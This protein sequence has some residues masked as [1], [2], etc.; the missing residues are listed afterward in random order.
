MMALEFALSYGD[1][2]CQV[3][4][5]LPAQAVCRILSVRITD[6]FGDVATAQPPPGRWNLFRH[7]D[8]AA[9]SGLGDVF[10]NAVP[11]VVADGEPIEEVHFLRDEQANLAWAVE[12]VVPHPLGGGVPAPPPPPAVPPPAG[13]AGPRWTLSPA[14]LPREWFP[15]L[16]VDDPPGRLVVGGLWT[17]RDVR[18]AGRV[19]GELL[20]DGRLQDREVP[21]KGVQVTRCWQAARGPDGSLHLWVGRAKTPRR[22]ELAPAVRFDLVDG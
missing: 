17:A 20:P 1:D 2:W 10:V 11:G 3:P 15:L 14:T 13:E 22:T 6:C 8:P 4:L 9:P 5:P 12:A 21:A 19:L 18:P 7:D 16:P